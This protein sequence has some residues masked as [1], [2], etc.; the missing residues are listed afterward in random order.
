MKPI[1][2][3]VEI[4]DMTKT[5]NNNKVLNQV[6]LSVAEGE[7]VTLLG[8][9]GCGKSTLLRALAGL[10][11]IDNGTITVGGKDIT[12]LPPKRRNIGMVFQSYALFPNM[13]AYDNI[14]F[15][16]KM[17]GLSKAEIRPLVEE[18][19]ALIDLKG[20]ENSYPDQLSGGQQQRVALAR[21]LVKKPAVLLLDEP[22]SALDAK[23]RRTI[24]TE[25][26]HIQRRLKMTTIFVT[27]DQEEALTISDRIFVMNHGN[28]EQEGTPQE[29][30]TSPR[31]EYVARFIGNYNV[32][33]RDQLQGLPFEG[34]PNGGEIFAVRPEAIVLADPEESSSAGELITAVG[35]ITMTT[36]LGNVIRFEVNVAGLIV[37]VDTLHEQSVHKLRNGSFVKLFIPHTEWK[38]I[39]KSS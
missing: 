15:G 11:D 38:S 5:Y 34:V 21:S 13:T 39:K 30:Y 9:S 23:I 36:V 29:I 18:M 32:W 26:R 31:S 10:N 6:S 7:F 33:S 17:E 4:R 37:T 20:K 12:H 24:R 19:I 28:I 25:I 8:P 27:H 14:A 16:L 22:L 1:M 35:T 3:F 2:N